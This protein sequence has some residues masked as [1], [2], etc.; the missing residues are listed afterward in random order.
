MGMPMFARH[1]DVFFDVHKTNEHDITN[2]D[3]YSYL[4]CHF[5]CGIG[6]S[7]ALT[8]ASFPLRR[9]PSEL[10]ALRSAH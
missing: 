2:C 1:P 6:A 4:R 7:L 9:R 8:P 5:I 10:V 3:V